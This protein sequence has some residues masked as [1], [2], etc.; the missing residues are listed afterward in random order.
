[1]NQL[2]GHTIYLVGLVEELIKESIKTGLM[3]VFACLG[4]MTVEFFSQK[5][6]D[7]VATSI[8][9]AAATVLLG[10]LLAIITTIKW[11]W[12]KRQALKGG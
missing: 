1:M 10:L 9:V 12:R 4:L 11:A 3:I 8:E 2:Q 6:L 5:P 7:L